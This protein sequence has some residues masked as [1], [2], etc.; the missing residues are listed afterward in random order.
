MN[1]KQELTDIVSG[2]FE[3]CGYGREFGM[4]TASNRPDLCQFQCNGAMAA[5]KRY[6]KAPIAI[7]DEVAEK[8][9]EDSRL[10]SVES[11]R[12]GFINISLS[13]IYIAELMNAMSSDGRLLLPVMEPKTIVV[14]YG[15]ANVAKPLHVGHFRSAIIGDTLC[16]LARLLGHKVISDVHLGDWGLQMGLVIAE[17]ERMDPELCCFDPE[18]NGEYPAEPPVTVDELNDIYPAASARAKTDKTFAA[19]AAKATVELQDGRAGYMALWKHVR[20][21]SIADLKRNYEALGVSFDFWYG[22]SDADKYIPRIIDTLKE[23]G[24]LRESDGAMV[25]DVALPE[26][27]EPMPPMLIVKSNGGDI[28]GTT[29]LGTILQRVE[30]WKPDEIWYAVDNR[31]ALH[32]KQVFRCAALAGILDGA[33]CTH[34]SF[35]TV[36]GKDG[37]PYKTR[38]GGVMRLSDMINDVTKSAYEKASGSDIAMSEEEK[39]AVARTVGVAAIKIGDMMNHRTK[40]FTFDMD[41]FLASEGKTGPY[42]QYAAVR[43][44]SLM[45]KARE[46]KAPLGAILPPASGEERELHLALLS[47]ADALP[48]AFYEKAPNIICEVMFEVAGAYNRFYF[49]NKI[50]TCPDTARRASWLSLSKLTGDMLGILL[51]LLGIGVP[52]SM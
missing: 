41:R 48:R 15:G 24:L 20:D 29:D 36:N 42:L 16:R 14:D 4:V 30:D 1:I 2:A 21:V 39:T 51:G 22:E 47:V 28:Y 5:A 49:E 32:F 46:A 44:N 50:L 6:K 9:G 26:D 8:L 37:K 25:V 17:I 34:I 7:A 12:P 23:K 40:D 38:E 18:H 13:D 3:R 31:Q 10:A 43:I 45:A 19:K 33:V 35:G 27:K 11:V 52:E